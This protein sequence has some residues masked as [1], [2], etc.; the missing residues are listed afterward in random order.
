[1]LILVRNPRQVNPNSSTQFHPHV[2]LK[3]LFLGPNVTTSL[4][5]EGSLVKIHR[6]VLG[7]FAFVL[8][9]EALLNINSCG[10]S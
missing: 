2:E 8:L 1:M 6:G 4:G 3:K 9:L 10:D 5:M 7:F